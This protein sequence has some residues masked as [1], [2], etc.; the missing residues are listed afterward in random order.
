VI[1]AWIIGR[2][3][4]AWGNDRG[5]RVA[6]VDRKCI[7]TVDSFFFVL[8]HLRF[9]YYVAKIKRISSFLKYSCA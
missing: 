7:Q 1:G 5:M 9:S 4:A 8:V 3:V 2:L 6:A